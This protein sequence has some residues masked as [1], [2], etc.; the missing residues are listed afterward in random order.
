MSVQSE[1]DR[2]SGNVADTMSALGEYGVDTTGAN[3]DDMAGLVRAIPKATIVQGTGDSEEA[4]MSQKAVTE[5]INKLT[6]EKVDKDKLEELVF[7]LFTDAS[8]V[9]L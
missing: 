5:E 8:E 3:S 6:N 2:I 1:I 7:A 9:A 4:V